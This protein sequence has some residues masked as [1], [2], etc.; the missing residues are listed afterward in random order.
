MAC[1]SCTTL[2]ALLFATCLVIAVP[3][4]FRLAGSI[5]A[6]QAIHIISTAQANLPVFNP[7]LYKRVMTFGRRP[8]DDMKRG[9]SSA[10]TLELVSELRSQEED[11]LSKRGIRG[12]RPFDDMKRDLSSDTTLGEDVSEPEFKGIVDLYKRGIRGGRR[13]FDDMKRDLSSDTTLREEVSEPEFKGIAN[14]YKRGIV[15]N[16]EL[17]EHRSP[18][19]LRLGG[20][21]HINQQ[22][23]LRH[24]PR[25]GRSC[26]PYSL[27]PFFSH[28]HYHYHSQGPVLFPPRD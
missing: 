27:T 1:L 10:T 16:Y 24:Q 3:V 22:Y 8:F 17:E 5:P 23:Y 14:L 11:R 26:P 7:V 4:P 19:S 20:R 15:Q 9:F 13:P 18:A 25:F 2:L 28:H 21:T 6:T 12:R